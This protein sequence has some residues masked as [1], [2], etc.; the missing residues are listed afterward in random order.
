[1]GVSDSCPSHQVESTHFP[2]TRPFLA[3]ALR[4]RVHWHEEHATRNKAEEARHPWPDL[5]KLPQTQQP[6]TR[7]LD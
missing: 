5:R 4:G 1:M 3:K 2:W 7:G 6:G